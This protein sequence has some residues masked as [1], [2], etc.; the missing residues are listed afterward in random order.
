MK[1]VDYNRVVSLRT[2]SGVTLEVCIQL[3]IQLSN[4][5]VD[6]AAIIIKFLEETKLEI[7]T[8]YTK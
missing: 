6:A 4:G 8:S 2:K 7:F 5:D 3:I 1:K